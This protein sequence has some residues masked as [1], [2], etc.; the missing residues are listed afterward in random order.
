[1]LNS[2]VFIRNIYQWVITVSIYEQRTTVSQRPAYCNKLRNIIPICNENKSSQ[3]CAYT[4]DTAV[5]ARIKMENWKKQNR[6]G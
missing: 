4:D 1:M 6:W 5:T 3:T 2:T